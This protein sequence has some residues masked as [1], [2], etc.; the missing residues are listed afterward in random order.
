MQDALPRLTQV[1]AGLM[2]YER[3]LALQ[4]ELHKAQ[5]EGTGGP[6]LI[7]VEHPPVLTFGKNA[8]RA[9]LLC[10]ASALREQGVTIVDTDRGGE[11]TA[12]EP[13]Q[14][15]AYPILRLSDFGLTPRSYVCLL[16][17]AVI[18]TLDLLGVAGT[19]DPE[20]PGVWVGR[21]KICALGVRIKQRVTLHGLALNVTNSLALF[22]KIVP[23]GIAGRGV[24]SLA[25]QLETSPTVDA[26]ASLLAGELARGLGREL[27]TGPQ[28]AYPILEISKQIST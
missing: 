4:M 14:L 19:T 17:K 9:H 8:D 13:G 20:H 16:E 2:D 7:L 5:V 25:L 23:C 6:Y 21:E 27:A 18:R 10:A 3:C 15:V 12:H 11:V 28:T 22:R 24:T 26:V 1:W